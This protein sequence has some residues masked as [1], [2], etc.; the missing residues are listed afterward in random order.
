[1]RYLSTRRFRRP[2]RVALG[3]PMP[4]ERVVAE[5]GCDPLKITAYLERDYRERGF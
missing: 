4:I 1:M 5:V 2:V 3:E